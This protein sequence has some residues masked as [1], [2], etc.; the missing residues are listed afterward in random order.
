[1]KE[2]VIYYTDELND[3]FAKT[4]IQRKPLGVKY[5]YIHK[6]TLWRVVCFIVYYVVAIP[7]VFIINKI[8]HHQRLKN[9]KVLKQVKKSGYFVYGN[10]TSH[11]N[12][13]FSVPVM[14]LP[15]RAY[16]ICNPDALSIK[17]LK[18]IVQM[19]GAIPLANTLKEHKEMV[20]CI[21]Q[22]IKEKQVISIYPEAHIWPYY[23]KI[24][25]FTNISFKYP[26]K[27]NAPVFAITHCFQKRKFSKKPKIISFVDGPFY[28]NTELSANE[29]SMELR[30]KVYQVM[31]DRAKK[32]SNYEYIKYVKV[33]EEKEY[34]EE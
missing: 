12:D 3:D 27:C 31:C 16:I 9:K 20:K 33:E 4:E 15:K 11:L 29:A 5:K 8:V 23:T 24:R 22:R 6:N 2:K 7:L 25:P 30:D 21:E 1:M 32:Y 10:H 13:C 14:A 34:I 19:L 26:V 18:N 28:P 17:G